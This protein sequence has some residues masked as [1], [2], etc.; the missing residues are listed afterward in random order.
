MRAGDYS[1]GLRNKED[2]L[3]RWTYRCLFSSQENTGGPLLHIP[4][5]KAHRAESFLCS[6]KVR[7]V[8]RGRQATV[9]EHAACRGGQN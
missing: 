6:Q 5:G 2:G 1:E 8:R 9:L 4:G 7:E 3:S